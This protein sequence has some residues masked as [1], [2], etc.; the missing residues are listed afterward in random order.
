MAPSSIADR[1]AQCLGGFESIASAHHGMELDESREKTITVIN[2]E[3]ARFKLWSGNIGAHR[4]GRSS[5][6]HRLRDS[7]R[8][9]EQV[10]RLLD[11]LATSLD[12]GM[13]I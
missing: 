11:E 3:L 2:D 7:S 4:M 8:L 5:L 13:L 12:E 6:D 10:A 1:V 9:R